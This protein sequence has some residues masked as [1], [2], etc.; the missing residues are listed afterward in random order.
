VPVERALAKNV[1]GTKQDRLNLRVTLAACPPGDTLVVTKLDELARSLR[2]ATDIAAELTA[3]GV[4]LNLDGS[5]Y[6]P[7]I[8]SAGYCS[9]CL[10]WSR[11]SNPTSSELAHARAWPPR[12]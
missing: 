3:K 6:D 2:D 4:R 9:M 11:S 7:P 10:A 5:A 8:W 1:A 12:R